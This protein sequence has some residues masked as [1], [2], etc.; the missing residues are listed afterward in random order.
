MTSLAHV[1]QAITQDM[2]NIVFISSETCSICHVDEPKVRKIAETN[3][4]TFHHLDIIQEP[5][6]TGLFSVMTVPAVL[7]YHNGK[8]VAR[9]ARF[10]DFRSLEELLQQLPKDFQ[11]TDYQSLFSEL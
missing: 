8:E 4:I 3:G 11:T 5:E 1:K 9:Q 6:L 2:N 10:I 7:V